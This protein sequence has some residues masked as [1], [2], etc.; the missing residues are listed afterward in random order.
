MVKNNGNGKSKKNELLKVASTVGK[1]Q[2][3]ISATNTKNWFFK[4]TV[5]DFFS[6]TRK[7]RI[8]SQQIKS[9]Q[10]LPETFKST[11]LQNGI[12]FETETVKYLK[13][14]LGP[15]NFKTIC[16]NYQLS[17]SDV[18]YRETI[19]AMREGVPIIYQGVVHNYTD[20]TYGIPDLLVRNDW[21]N[22]LIKNTTIINDNKMNAGAPGLG[23]T[24][25]YR[26]V[27][28]KCSTLN[29]ASNGI[30]L[31][32]SGSIPSYKGQLCIYNNALSEM[33]G[34]DPG[35][36][37]ILGKRWTT[38]KTIHGRKI[39]NN[40][41]N[42]FDRLGTIDYTGYDL[43]YIVETQNAINWLKELDSVGDKWQLFPP[44]DERLY[45]N[46]KNDYDYPYHS[47]KKELADQIGEITSI[48]YCGVKNRK[49]ALEKG[50]S[51]W[52]DPN[53]NAEVLGHKGKIAEIVNTILNVNRSNGHPI[54]IDK[55]FID[56]GLHNQPNS[57]EFFV[58]Y[59]T[60]SNV[61]DQPTVPTNIEYNLIYM[62]GVGYIDP[63]N[64]QWIYRD[65]TVSTCSVAEENR[66]IRDWLNYMFDVSGNDRAKTLQAPIYHWSH[67]EQTLFE[68]KQ[69]QNPLIRE[70]NV[71][72]WI[73]LCKVFT[74][75][76]IV[77]KGAL[78]FG[79]KE[80]ARAMYDNK[81]I[82]SVWS[83]DNP[84]NN[85][86]ESMVIFKKIR[87]A[88]QHEGKDIRQVP[89]L[90]DIVDYNELDCKVMCEILTF[91]RQEASH[92]EDNQ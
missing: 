78:N 21:L 49:K 51:S 26:V 88:A 27:D 4:D 12:T 64:K 71:G 9:I 13:S 74:D 76:P 39:V 15:E 31:L 87:D 69:S 46:M 75:C 58:D 7:G 41:N 72:N 3:T 90:K 24:W 53:C 23:T 34:F 22:K 30:N 20:G 66:I 17:K 28:I 33:Q 63:D 40:G 25:H 61:V 60:I 82:Q 79:L 18:M 65:F 48:W 59:E 89:L 42:C 92:I 83:T 10:P 86:L 14:Q 6:R 45:P 80:V 73:D 52:R 81:L 11:I 77:P 62:I 29:L 16:I 54:Y 8:R 57:V 36:C 50:I 68:K 70:L 44:S 32:N 43:D 85:G 55:S 47:E 2:L 67:I 19:E 5:L 37:Y 1:S 35:R 91:L 38:S 84:C 56:T